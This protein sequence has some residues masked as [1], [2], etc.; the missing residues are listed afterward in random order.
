MGISKH[1]YRQI[2]NDLD[3]ARRAAKRTPYA[4]ILIVCEGE[5]T[6]PNYFEGLKNELKLKG[7]S[8]VIVRDSDFTPTKIAKIAKKHYRQ[9]KKAGNPFKKVF[10]V[11][12]KDQHSGYDNALEQIQQ[13]KPFGVFHAIPSVPC[14][15]YFLLLHYCYTAM[16]FSNCKQAEIELKKHLSTY[17]KGDKNIFA[18]VRDHLE[19][20]KTRAAKSLAEAERNRTCNPSTRAHELVEFMQNIKKS[21]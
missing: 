19:T 15:E 10:C 18:T 14:F 16:P 4:R 8:V 9:E 21:P 11:F 5:K 17:Q 20:A 12:D 2:K 7:T 13:E 1:S 6:E 3:L